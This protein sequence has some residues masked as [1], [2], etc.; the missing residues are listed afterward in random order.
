MKLSYRLAIALIIALLATFLVA[1]W[2]GIGTSR[3]SG[4]LV[5][6]ASNTIEAGAQLDAKQLKIMAWSGPAAPPG[7]FSS[8]EKL[9]KRVARQ[10]IYAGEPILDGKLAMEGESAGLAATITSGKRAITVRVND[11]IGVTGFALPGSFVDILVSVKQAQQVEP[12]SKVVLN[13]VK[14]LAIAQETDA[15]TSKPKV[16]N[17]VTLELT[18][19][20]AE[21]LDLARTV[22]TLSLVLRN[23][24]DTAHAESGGTSLSDLTGKKN[25]VAANAKET[26][27]SGKP[28]SPSRSAARRPA[29]EKPPVILAQPGIEVIRG[30]TKVTETKV[31]ATKVTK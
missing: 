4:P 21:K 15:D 9:T 2:L 7:S 31:T 24:M 8:I 18:P 22:G 10:K 12:F 14:V 6:F 28:A 3:S 26:T 20:E 23:E 1:R 13:R 17:A 19:E 25:P 5:V 30:I 29:K 11:V 16:V 27:K